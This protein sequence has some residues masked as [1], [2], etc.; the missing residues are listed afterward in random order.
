MTPDEFRQSTELVQRMRELLDDP[1]MKLW[2]ESLENDNPALKPWPSG[3]QPHEAH[4]MLGE[5]GGWMLYRNNFRLGGTRI[6]GPSQPVP[7]DYG[8]IEQEKP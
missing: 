5:Q 2:L 1:A 4:I 6:D 8:A 3:A 7:Q